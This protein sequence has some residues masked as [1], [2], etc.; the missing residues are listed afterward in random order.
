MTDDASLMLDSRY[1]Y[2]GGQVLRYDL[3]PVQ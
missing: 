3:P 1:L 2:S